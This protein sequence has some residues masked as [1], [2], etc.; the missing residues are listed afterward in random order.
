MRSTRKEKCRRSRSREAFTLT[1]V[2]VALA[3]SALGIAGGLSMLNSQWN[4]I[5]RGQE[6]LYVGHILE[7]RLEEVRDLTFEELD[8]LPLDFDFE[9]LPAL[10]IYGRPVNPNL[11]GEGNEAYEREL[12]DGVGKVFIETLDTDLRKITIEVTWKPALSSDSVTAVTTAYVTR[13]GVNRK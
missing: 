11:V 1:E 13:N 12:R 9:I 8:A 7:S 3:I 2:M 6:Q 4:L 5:R 10:T